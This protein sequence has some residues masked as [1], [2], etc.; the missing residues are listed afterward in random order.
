MSTDDKPDNEKAWQVLTGVN[1]Y[2]MEEV[3]NTFADKGFNIFKILKSN[4]ELY[5]KQEVQFM[6]VAFN[7]IKMG[8]NMARVMELNQKASSE[9]LQILMDA[10]GKKG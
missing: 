2:E 7:P 5:E 1:Q 4:V 10:L 6:V 3:L 9:S 8:Q